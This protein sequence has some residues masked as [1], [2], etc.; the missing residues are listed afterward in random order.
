MKSS[1][2][3][4]IDGKTRNLLR[5]VATCLLMLFV[6]ACVTKVE[7]QAKL[8]EGKLVPD[9]WI[10]S[11]TAD[12]TSP[13]IKL[14]DSLVQSIERALTDNF[15]IKNALSNVKIAETNVARNNAQLLPRVNA[16]LSSSK[17]QSSDASSQSSPPAR[18][19]GGVSVRWQ[20]DVWNK[21]SDLQK[22]SAHALNSNQFELNAAKQ[23]VISRVVLAYLEVQRL[24][25]LIDI[26]KQNLAQE[27]RKFAQT[28]F[29][30]DVGLVKSKDYRLALNA[31]NRIKSNVLQQQLD[32]HRA[33]Q[34]F[35]LL[36]GR[37]SETE[38]IDFS[39][40]VNVLEDVTVISPKHILNSRPDLV[41]SEYRL[42]SLY[43]QHK[44][45]GK[46]F[47]P[48]LNLNLSVGP[49]SQT[50]LMKL[51]DWQYWAGSIVANLSQNVFDGGIAKANMT[52][53]KERRAIANNNY[54]RD[55]LNAWQEIEHL[56]NQEQTQKQLLNANQQVLKNISEA[57]FIIQ[58]EYEA[59][60][61]SSV[62]LLS[63][64]NQR[65]SAEA[66][67]INTRYRIIR[68]RVNLILALGE[69]LVAVQSSKQG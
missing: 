65:R 52:Q 40:P 62:D 30:L 21:L 48:D 7:E 46:A 4:L 24:T 34:N 28:E 13:K 41:A 6:V 36:L 67:L 19:N 58:G 57:E 61:S 47:L 8:T 9:S 3:R 35:N 68:N 26:T 66:N 63:I 15:D 60:L 54:Q 53:L 39:Q 12:H 50:S 2:N 5:Y 11:E 45:S 49:N 25:E 29:K 43:Y 55:I 17:N 44:Q 33:K 32:L 18:F 20:L 37:Y 56:L 31:I 22:A 10:Y 42:S 69:S 38:D 27:Q 51:F 1:I 14:P 16:S 64:Q 23:L 59:G